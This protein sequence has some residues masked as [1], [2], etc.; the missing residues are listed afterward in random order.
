[1]NNPKFLHIAN[2]R[3]EN[4]FQAPIMIGGFYNWHLAMEGDFNLF[5]MKQG[6]LSD[7]DVLFI[8]LS[9]PELEGT[10]ASIIRR[11]IGPKEGNKTKLVICIDYA[12]ELWQNVFNPFSL[13]NEILQADLVFVSEPQMRKW[14]CSVVNDRIPV[15][16]IAHPTNIDALRTMYKP[17]SLRS[18]EIIALIHRYDNNWMAPYLATKNLPWNTHAVCLDPNIQQH[19]WAFFKYLHGGFEFMQYLE[20]A[21]RKSAVIDSYHRIH[22]YGRS[23]VDNA[24]LRLPT[25]GA[26]WT[27]AQ[28]FLWPELTVEAGDVHT[29]GIMLK[30]LFEDSNFY[31][32]CTEF[33]AEKV[34]M[35]SYKNRKEDLLNKLYN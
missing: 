26:D 12:I 10:V 2:H 5:K 18:E 14:V 11:E 35:F 24:C 34:E 20:W 8:G 17:R 9:K 31:D 4:L 3:H 19:I 33:A 23:A 13:E 25:V 1:M 6:T 15:H 32:E 7:Y 29:Q 27:W 16:Q 28:K 21:S 30:K 22:T